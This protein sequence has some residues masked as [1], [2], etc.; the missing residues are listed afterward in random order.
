MNLLLDKVAVVTG[1]ARGIGAATALAC[2]REG[3]HVVV[4]DLNY[5]GAAAVASQIEGMGRIGLAIQ[6]DVSKSEDLAKIVDLTLDKFARIDVLINNAGIC[7]R[8]SVADLTEA[9]WDRMLNINLKSAFFLTQ[10]VLTVMKKQK[11]GKIINLASQAG[12]TGGQ[13][14]GANYAVSKAGMINLTKSLAKDAGPYGINVNAVA[15]GFIDTEM[16]KDFGVDVNAIP[17]RRLGTAE[18]VADVIVFL[19]SDLSRYI[20]GSTIDINGGTT[21]R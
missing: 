12:E 11:S 13:F 1:G 9:D 7:Q 4:A 14:V 6:A 3:A 20:T 17:L 16:T 18:D 15:P 8:V 2:A 5:E 10:K 19:A 21:M